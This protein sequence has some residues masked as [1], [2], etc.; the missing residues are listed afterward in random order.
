MSTPDATKLPA[1][2]ALNAAMTGTSTTG[3]TPEQIDHLCAGMTLPMIKRLTPGVPPPLADEIRD[4]AA[5]VCAAVGGDDLT[6]DPTRERF[7]VLVRLAR[8]VPG[9]SEIQRRALM[10]LEVCLAS[11][12]GGHRDVSLRALLNAEEALPRTHP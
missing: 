1:S 8:T 5:A 2:A 9:R 3:L 11:A 4:R 10:H 12:S 6:G 7:R